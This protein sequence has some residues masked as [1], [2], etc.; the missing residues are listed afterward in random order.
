[1]KVEKT[2]IIPQNVLY[3]PACVQVS[4]DGD[5]ATQ[6]N[7]ANYRTSESLSELNLLDQIL[8]IQRIK[9]ELGIEALA[10][11]DLNSLFPWSRTEKA[12]WMGRAPHNPDDLRKLEERVGKELNANVMVAIIDAMVNIVQGVGSEKIPNI[13]YRDSNL[14]ST[15]R[16]VPLKDRPFAPYTFSCGSSMARDKAAYTLRLILEK[17][18]EQRLGVS[19]ERDTIKLLLT[20]SSSSVR[21]HGVNAATATYKDSWRKNIESI[22][23]ITAFTKEE[24]DSVRQ[25]ISYAIGLASPKSILERYIVDGESF[26]LLTRMLI[27]RSYA[28]RRNILW[29]LTEVFAAQRQQGKYYEAFKEVPEL[30]ARNRIDSFDSCTETVE[31]LCRSSL[32]T[33]DELRMLHNSCY[34]IFYSIG[35]DV[36]KIV[37]AAGLQNDY[38]RVERRLLQLDVI[39]FIKLT[40]QP[41]VGNPVLNTWDLAYKAIERI[42]H[43]KS[44]SHD[45]PLV[46]FF[47][48]KAAI[49]QILDLETDSFTVDNLKNASDRIDSAVAGYISN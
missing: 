38:N 46:Y 22:G 36:I 5:G 27:D 24:D 21:N 33:K 43:L 20:A 6:Q 1:M 15:A 40:T 41:V 25:N 48:L 23:L 29:G 49:K 16:D 31:S 28:V 11:A 42:T 2:T 8:I 17:M 10:A 13:W 3:L 35:D 9:N 45:K 4:Q 37:Q 26:C 14:M 32:P 30:T 47:D 7:H 18:G 39:R 44:K 34:V 12:R 19:D